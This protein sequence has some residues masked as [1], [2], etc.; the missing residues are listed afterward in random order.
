[1]ESLFSR[2]LVPEMRH[3]IKPGSPFWLHV[4]GRK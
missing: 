4:P 2:E 3:K 1:M